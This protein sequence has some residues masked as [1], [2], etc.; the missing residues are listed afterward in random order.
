MPVQPRPSFLNSDISQVPLAEQERREFEAKEAHKSFLQRM[1][2]HQDGADVLPNQVPAFTGRQRQA[3]GQVDALNRMMERMGQNPRIQ[4]LINEGHQYQPLSPDLERRMLE[5]Q[6]RNPLESKTYSDYLD[7]PRYQRLRDIYRDEATEHFK[8][9][10]LPAVR[11]W[12][13]LHGSSNS[14]SRA[15]AEAEELRKFNVRTS[16]DLTKMLGEQHEKAADYAMQEENRL[17]EERAHELAGRSANK[18]GFLQTAEAHRAADQNLINNEVKRAQLVSGVGTAEQELERQ[19]LA[20]EHA[21]AEN[22]NE[23]EMN[24]VRNLMSTTAQLPAS[25]PTTTQISSPAPAVPT[26]PLNA[27]SGIAQTMYSHLNPQ[28]RAPGMKAGGSVPH[29]QE[30]GGMPMPPS[31]PQGLPPQQ[32]SSPQEPLPQMPNAP[33]TPEQ[34]ILLQMVE[35]Y[36][37]KAPLARMFA[38]TGANQLANPRGNAMQSFG[39]GML[40]HQEIERGMEK[41]HAD[42]IE[43]VSQSR[44]DQHKLLTEMGFK[45]RELDIDESHK[46]GLI[47]VAQQ[48]AAT[49]KA[50]KEAHSELFKAQKESYEAERDLKRRELG[51]PGEDKDDLPTKKLTPQREEAIKKATHEAQASLN[52]LEAAHHA[53]KSLEGIEGDS[54]TEV[55][56]D[57]PKATLG[58]GPL[59]AGAYQGVK[60]DVINQARGSVD[61]FINKLGALKETNVGRSIAHMQQ[62]KSG[63]G[64]LGQSSA[65]NKDYFRKAQDIAIA[66]YK[67]AIKDAK[68]SGASINEIREM[69]EKLVPFEQKEKTQVDP[70][71]TIDPTPETPITDPEHLSNDQLKELIAKKKAELGSS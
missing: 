3:F 27:A 41:Q 50:Y 24:A 28:Q 31:Q 30:G 18:P 54:F 29:F 2:L 69:E 36:Q 44:H 43:K 53:N 42:T 1:K 48:N 65:Y 12:H 64:G 40:K 52:I 37:K 15:N 10:V 68:R 20:Q 57:Y 7:N 32:P 6:N 66:N 39:E 35:N 56:G 62:T 21:R 17:K 14:S 9:S 61:E 8:R 5:A 22:A 60:P 55:L 4:N 58:L 49:D 11:T 46:K 63:K 13:A 47:G 67:L 19:K 51:Q 16:R 25:V 38:T 33:Y 45:K 34:R 70:L 26:N 23:F 59:I 71:A